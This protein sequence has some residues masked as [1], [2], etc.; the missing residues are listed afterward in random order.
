MDLNCEA[1]TYTV[2]FGATN[3]PPVVVTSTT[4]ATF[5]PG[6][7]GAGVTYFWQITAHDGV[8]QTASAVWSFTTQ[9]LPEVYLYLPLVL[10]GPL[11][12]PRLTD[13]SLLN[14]TAEQKKGK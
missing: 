13:F 4:A 11:T 14:P 8:T 7:L 6:L 12:R 5:D 9:P 10:N 3:P 1:L 2:A